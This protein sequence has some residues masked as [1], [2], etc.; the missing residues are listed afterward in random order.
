[1]SWLMGKDVKI[2]HRDL[3]PANIMLDRGQTS[4]KICDFGLA[5]TNERKG[6]G[7]EEHVGDIKSTRGSPLWMAPER[8]AIKVMADEELRED[9][10]TEVAGYTKSVKVDKTT[11]N[12]SEKSDVYSFGVMLWE[13]TTQQWPFVEMLAS[14]SFAELFSLILSGRRPSLRDVE[15]SLA[16]II[17]K[18]WQADPAN[19][20]TFEQCIAMLRGARIDLALP[21]TVCPH[22]AS[23]W[24]ITRGLTDLTTTVGQ[25]VT[26]LDQQ[27]YLRPQKQ[28]DMI[29][30][31]DLVERCIGTIL[32][33]P[34]TSV[35]SSDV[36]RAQPF[37]I[38]DFSKLLKWFGPLKGQNVRCFHNMVLLLKSNWFFGPTERTQCERDCDAV[39][40][41][42]VRLNTG[43]SAPIE[44]SPFVISTHLKNG[45][46]FHIRVVAQRAYGKWS[47]LGPPP[48]QKRVQADDLES[49]IIALQKEGIISMACP[50]YPYGALFTFA[51]SAP[52][53][54]SSDPNFELEVANK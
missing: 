13:I 25:F 32:R 45:T 4:C 44:T 38:A 8:V 35:L 19:R 53:N 17:E 50:K 52:S 42:L 16:S 23:F 49:L 28:S 18:C 31:P 54:Y 3:K 37:T 26:G 51:P 7:K 30:K 29:L 12:S 15:P 27:G 46:P 21:M 24:K 43:G 5:V 6:R 33:S 20:P 40:M 22:A 9:L 14:E 34:G 39:G 36:A 48:E 1:M 10:A 11:S 2:I 41:F 47:C